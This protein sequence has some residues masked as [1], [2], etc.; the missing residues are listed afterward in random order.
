M[1]RLTLFSESVENHHLLEVLVKILLGR[2]Q[3][4][5]L[6]VPVRERLS[7]TQAHEKL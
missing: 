1:D 3:Q 4:R 7:Q 5:L 6:T 2:E